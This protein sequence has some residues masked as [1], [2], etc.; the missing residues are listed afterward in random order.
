MKLLV[1]NC[2]SEELAHVAIERGHAEAT[3]VRWIGKGDW[4]D[5]NLKGL[6]DDGGY[7]FVTKNSVDFR[8]PKNNKGS[9]GEHAKLALHAG[10]ICLNGPL[11]MDLDLQLELFL[12]ALDA[13]DED[14][15]LINVALEV[16]L[17]SFEDSELLVERYPI[18]KS[19]PYARPIDHASRATARSST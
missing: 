9:K 4:K 12:T 6:I 18:P 19:G 1:D 15:D 16:T 5:W 14:A 13:I 17:E 8:G 11:G 10:L 7:T 2:L 3:H